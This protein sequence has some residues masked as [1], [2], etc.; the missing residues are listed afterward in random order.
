MWAG[1]ERMAF[2]KVART[3]EIPAGKMKRVDWGE[4]SILIANVAGTYYAMNDKCTHMGTDLSGGTLEGTIVTCPK[5]GQRFDITTGKSI[6]GPKVAFISMKGMDEPTFAV[7]V[8]GTDLLVD[9][10]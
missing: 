6:R 2:T 1:G 3:S 7:K 10:Q 9:I 5:H 4:N 8:E